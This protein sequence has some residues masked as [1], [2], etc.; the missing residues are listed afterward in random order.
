M[1]LN[2]TGLAGRARL[3]GDCRQAP[4]TWCSPAGAAPPRTR[5][6]KPG[7]SRS[8]ASVRHQGPAG[9]P[10]RL[11][12]A[13]GHGR[14]RQRQL[15]RRRRR[16]ATSPSRRPRTACSSRSISR[17]STKADLDPR[18]V[19]DHAVG[20]FYYSFVL[21]C[22][23]GAVGGE[24]RQSWADLFDTKKFP[25]QAHLLQMVGAGRASRSRCWPMA[26]R[27]TSSIRS[28]STGP[29]RSSTPSSPTS[30]G[31]AAVPSRSSCSPPA[32]PPSASS[33][34]AASSRLQQDGSRRRRPPGTR[35]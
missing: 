19:T 26:C 9:W 23:K 13:Q 12:Q 20:S 21:G 7:P 31:G 11:R 34:T 3:G 17:S 16:E 32:R 5:R 1:K 35:T 18:F 24:A 15:G 33:G 14:S 22:N 30:S 28:I 29:S 6:P 4:T 10:D 2:L 25:G 8:P 27:P